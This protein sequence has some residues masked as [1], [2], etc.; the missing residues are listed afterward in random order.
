MTLLQDSAASPNLYETIVGLIVTSDKIDE[1]S[2]HVYLSADCE[3]RLILT[4]GHVT[5][6]R[7]NHVEFLIMF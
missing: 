4:L 1:D 7:N 2:D 5:S 3:V 6:I